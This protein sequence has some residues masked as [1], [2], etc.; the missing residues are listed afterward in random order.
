MF[1][2]SKFQTRQSGGAATFYQNMK[3]GVTD[4]YSPSTTINGQGYEPQYSQGGSSSV[5]YNTSSRPLHHNGGYASLYPQ[6]I[7]T[8]KTKSSSDVDFSLDLLRIAEEKETRT[9]VMVLISNILIP[10]VLVT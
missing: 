8:R 1:F 6:Q 5:D 10:L 3:H 4:R 2:F 7:Q 9:T